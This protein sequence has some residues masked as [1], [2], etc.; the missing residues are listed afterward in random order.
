MLKSD[1]PSPFGDTRLPYSQ[2][3]LSAVSVLESTFMLENFLSEI[4]WAQLFWITGVS[5]SFMQS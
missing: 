3:A 5:R 4:D 2:A 1:P